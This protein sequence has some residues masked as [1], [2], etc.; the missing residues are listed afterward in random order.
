MRFLGGKSPTCKIC[1]FCGVDTPTMVDFKLW[2]WVKKRCPKLALESPPKPTLVR[3]CIHLN[4]GLFSNSF[5]NSV[6]QVADQCLLEQPAKLYEN[7]LFMITLRILL[8]IIYSM[9]LILICSPFLLGSYSLFVRGVFLSLNPLSN[10]NPFGLYL[11]W[12]VECSSPKTWSNRF[13]LII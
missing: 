4:L 11:F 3:Y 1:H 8:K 6:A 2:R 7:A 5:W 10:L 12:C 9:V 13:F